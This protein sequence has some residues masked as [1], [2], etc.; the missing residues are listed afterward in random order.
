[1]EWLAWLCSVPEG[2]GEDSSSVSSLSKGT[3][4]LWALSTGSESSNDEPEMEMC[5][6]CCGPASSNCAGAGSEDGLATGSARSLPRGQPQL[7][8]RDT[9]TPVPRAHGAGAVPVGSFE[10]G[11]GGDAEDPGRADGDARLDGGLLADAEQAD[12]PHVAVAVAHP[13]LVG[14]FWAA[15]AGRS[16]RKLQGGKRQGEVTWERQQQGGGKLASPWARGMLK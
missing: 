5:R 15:V 16:T 8:H 10:A 6:H 7:Q 4:S 2:L 9:V 11:H 1:M 12:L 3:S 13:D 14:V